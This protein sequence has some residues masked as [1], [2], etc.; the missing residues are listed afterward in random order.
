MGMGL[1]W[2]LALGSVE[3]LKVYKTLK[4]ACFPL[5]PAIPGLFSKARACA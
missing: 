3:T 4:V 2:R 1:G 5:F